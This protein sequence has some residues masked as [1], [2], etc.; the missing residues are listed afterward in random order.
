MVVEGSYHNGNYYEFNYAYQDLA[1]VQDSTQGKLLILNISD[2]SNIYQITNLPL[3]VNQMHIMDNL[4]YFALDSGGLK[5]YNIS[6]I[7]NPSLMSQFNPGGRFRSLEISQ[8]LAFLTH[9]AGLK[10][11]NIIL[12]IPYLLLV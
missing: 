6:D 12:V 1:F 8:D 10:I 4:A 7:T 2:F 9:S 5:I 3:K 11:I